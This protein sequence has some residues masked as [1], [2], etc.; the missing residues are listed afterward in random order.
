MSG[1]SQLFRSRPAP[2]RAQI[3]L[4]FRV[5]RR[6]R[7]SVPGWESIEGQSHEGDRLHRSRGS[8]GALYFDLSNH[9]W[10][11]PFQGCVRHTYVDRDG[12]AGVGLNNPVFFAA[13]GEFTGTVSGVSRERIVERSG[14]RTPWSLRSL[15]AWRPRGHRELPGYQCSLVLLESKVHVTV[16][17]HQTMLF[18]PAYQRF[19]CRATQCFKR[20][21]L[22]QWWRLERS[23][24][25]VGLSGTDPH[26][27]SIELLYMRFRV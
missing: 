23:F 11:R 25:K 12:G 8:A 13:T 22:N 10:N 20:L 2:A 1:L 14:N 26:Q 16:A 18:L 17:R 9:W 19:T 7:I 6:G 5:C 21:K 27:A 3:R 24:R 15:R 4:I